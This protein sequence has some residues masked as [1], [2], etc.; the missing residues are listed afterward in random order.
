MRRI[1]GQTRRLGAL[2]EQLETRTMLAGDNGPH[3]NDP[4]YDLGNFQIEANLQLWVDGSQIAIPA[5]VGV[6]GSG[7]LTFVHTDA[8]DNKL[9]IDNTNGQ[10]ASDFVTLGDFFDTWRTDGGLAGNNPDSFLSDLQ[11][12]DNTVD[13]E[14]ALQ[15]YVNGQRTDAFE[16]YQ[17]HDGDRIV[18]VYTSNPVVVIETNV[19]T[20]L[21]EVFADPVTNPDLFR[22]G[23]NGPVD[24]GATTE[25]FLDLINSGRFDNT[26]IH[27]LDT[28]IT[29]RPNP[30]FVIQGGGFTTQTGAISDIDGIASV[31]QVPSITN[32]PG[33][34]NGLGTIAMARGSGVNSATTEVFV[35]LGDNADILDNQN[36]GFTAFGQVLDM[37]PVDEIVALNTQVVATN[38]FEASLSGGQQIPTVAT[39]LT[40]SAALNYNSATD[41]FDLDILLTGIAASQLTGSN[42]NMGGGT[43]VEIFDLGDGTQ[44]VEENGNLRRTLSGADFPVAEINNLFNDA[45]FIDIETSA[46]PNGEIRGQLFRRELGGSLG[47]PPVTA[48][49]DFVFFQAFAGSATI[50][51]TIFNDLNSDGVFD[52]ADRPIVDA[53]AFIDANNNGVLDDGETSTRTA[54]DGSYFF[55]VEAG[56][57]IIREVAPDKFTQTSPASP[58][59]RTVTLEIGETATD[60]DF[61]NEADFQNSISGFVYFDSNNNGVK[62]ANES[63]IANVTVTLRDANGAVVETRQTLSDGSYRFDNLTPGVYTIEETQP[64]LLNDG[65][66]TIGSQGGDDSVN[67]EFTV[68]VA[69]DT[70]GIENNFGELAPSQQF[71]DLSE[72]I[73]RREDIGEFANRYQ[74][75]LLTVVEANEGASWSALGASWNGSTITDI[76]ASDDGQT[77]TFVLLDENQQKFRAELSV[78][79]FGVSFLGKEDGLSVLRLNGT[80]DDFPFVRETNTT[81]QANNEA[82]SVQE[83][84]SLSVSATLGVLANDQDSDN[85]VLSASVVN[86]PA[87]G[88]VTLNGDGSF[89]YAPNNGFVG[90]DSFTYQA[91]DGLASSNT[92]VVNITVTAAPLAVN[93]FDVDENSPAGTLIGRIDASSQVSGDV[94]FDLHDPSTAEELRLNADDHLSGN[95]MGSIVL[96]EYLDFQCPACQA[97]HPIVEQVRQ[98]FPDDLLVVTRHL[99]LNTIHPNAFEAAIAAEAAG[100]QGMFD[101]MADLLFDRQNQWAALPDPQPFFDGLA[102]E[103]GL[104]ATQFQSDTNDPALA[105]RVNRDADAA[106]T[107]G[108]SGTPTFVLEGQ[109]ITPSADANAFIALVQAELDVL[110]DVFSI[111]RLTGDLFVRDTAALDFE[112]TPTFNQTIDVANGISTTLDAT[113][114]LNDLAD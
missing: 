76:Q 32:Q 26:L 47:G 109:S 31:A 95:T 106:A 2:L 114:N 16:D 58:N 63:P 43:P 34:T 104:D 84:Q 56:T 100:R 42:L 18:L 36:D 4:Q 23:E 33:I 12:F 39:N 87:N 15:L 72:F 77:F 30:N 102:A 110:D 48:S 73:M 49:D 65:M 20:L 17:I 83:N 82:Y 46:F 55:H 62:E 75:T 90:N 50:Q 40:G 41:Q 68:T 96:I 70:E 94:I 61:G 60:V 92:A 21:V 89:T 27:R 103:I 35:N 113:I 59:S 81:P 54:Q 112:T 7:P 111:D 98:A 78:N 38:V 105:D 11:L 19:S 101:E 29:S 66:D 88:S 93:T 28:S 53:I 64:V 52:A 85:D 74:E 80:N 69:A 8:T 86:E 37:A 24:V 79:N 51:G 14:H 5:N 9:Q 108:F 22:A 107:L 71:V 97:F 67:D 3:N 25:N 10:V 13:A 1:T 44:W 45:I 91:N 6:G 57:H 99:P